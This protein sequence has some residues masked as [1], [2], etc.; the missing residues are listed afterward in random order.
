VP[1]SRPTDA[2]RITA[3]GPIVW[4]YDVTFDDSA[5]TLRVKA[6]F[7][8][9]AIDEDTVL[10]VTEG[11]ESFVRDLASS[12]G[13]ILRHHDVWL[14]PGCSRGCTLTYD[15]ALDEAGGGG[16]RHHDDLASGS[17]GALQA[18]PGTWLV[19]PMAA[20]DSDRF[21][22]VVHVPPNFAF[23]TGARTDDP[24]GT[25]FTGPARLLGR[26]PY[27]LFGNLRKRPVRIGDRTAL[28][29]LG[30]GER[31]APDDAYA[32]WVERSGTVVSQTF[33]RFPIDG[34]MIGVLPGRGSRVGFGRAVAGELGG[35]ILVDVGFTTEEPAL[36]SDWV[37]VHEMIHLGFP[38][39]DQR[40]RWMEEGLATYL[41]PLLRA[42][43]GILSTSNV[44][45][46][47]ISMMH[48]GLPATGDEGIDR[49]PT[50]G[51]TYW[52][53]ALFCFVADVE[54]RNRTG[55][56]KSLDDA[57]RAILDA[58]G[59]NGVRW[60]IEKA[61]A[62]GDAATGEKVLGKLYSD[63]KETP[64]MVDLSKLYRDLGVELVGETV[65]FDD[66]APL[67]SVRRQLTTSGAPSGAP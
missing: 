3:D 31:R 42:R 14:A 8:P 60:P 32:A 44:W 12:A 57:L 48:N 67:A 61:F 23:A 26:A 52:G 38:S 7:A 4:S 24:A 13:R 55:G 22:V 17:G 62:V 66:A 65:R 47:F 35:S 51:R 30:P 1:T 45:D 63:W 59:N 29:V 58:G 5:R 21:R 19:R 16:R 2:T 9:N 10:S 34:A 39:L 53:G 50:W 28:L 27:T 64:V 36:R 43:A 18:P 41:E 54:I 15:Y 46:E 6:Q 49:T 37:L 20:R 56:K 33:G 11:A 40:H 25:T